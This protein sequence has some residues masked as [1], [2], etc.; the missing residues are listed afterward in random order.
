M[1]SYNDITGDKIATRKISKEY[2]NNF[3]NIFR[4]NKVAEATPAP[5]EPV[6]PAQLEL[7]TE[8]EERRLEIIGQNGNIGYEE[9]K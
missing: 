2:G 7:W 4:K 3:D 9:I 5:V 1:A 6:E 8:E